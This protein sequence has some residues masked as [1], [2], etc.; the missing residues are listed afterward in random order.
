MD[1]EHES[2]VHPSTLGPPLHSRVHMGVTDGAVDTEHAWLRTTPTSQP[3]GGASE[4][5]RSP[6]A[7]PPT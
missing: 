1:S 3:E 7:T 6:D 2:C 4:A 5:P